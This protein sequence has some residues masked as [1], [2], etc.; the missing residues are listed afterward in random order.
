MRIRLASVLAVL[1]LVA[2]ACGAAT[3]IPS[4]QPSPTATVAAVA[5]PATVTDFQNPNHFLIRVQEVSALSDAQK[6]AVAMKRAERDRPK[7]EEIESAGEKLRL[8]G[9]GYS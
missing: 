4:R 8:V 3:P 7:N 6:D 5:F 2:S 1:L 9:H